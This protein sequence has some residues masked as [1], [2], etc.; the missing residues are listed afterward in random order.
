MNVSTQVLNATQRIQ[1]LERQ[2]T[3]RLVVSPVGPSGVL[4]LRLLMQQPVVR[5]KDVERHLNVSYSKANALV[6]GTDGEHRT[7]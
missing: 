5:V 3:D 2:D 6:A 4:L 1:Q 7:S